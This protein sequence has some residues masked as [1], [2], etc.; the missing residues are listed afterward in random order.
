MA[1]VHRKPK[2]I[3]PAEVANEQILAKREDRILREELAKDLDLGLDLKETLPTNAAELLR[4]EWDKKAFG[5]VKTTTRVVYGPDPLVT[6]CP[7]FH[8]RLE[9]YGKAEVADAFR[10]LIMEKG[11]MACPDAV[12]RR[13]VRHAISKFG[14]EAT[15]QAFYDRI[16]RIPE[17]TVEFDADSA[18]DPLLINP[19]REAV[20]R[21]GRPG[22]TVKF[23]SEGCNRRFGLRGYQIVKDD[24][25]DPVKIGTLIMGE[26]PTEWA[27]R[28]RQHWAD[29][30]VAQIAEQEQSYQDRATQAIRDSRVTGVAPL[31]RGES[32]RPSTALNDEW[33]NES[34]ETGIKVG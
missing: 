2:N 30:S 6:N 27:D 19:M 5:D 3:D 8:D 10:S 29:E 15:S 33:L 9:R 11:E 12:M 28:R 1:L 34:R 16:M 17:R 22:F 21:Y 14:K 31:T 32:M 23:L 4:D 13:G 18:L 24:N 7:E 25:G 26:I 20:D